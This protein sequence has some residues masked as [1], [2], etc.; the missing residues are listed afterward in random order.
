MVVRFLLGPGV[1]AACSLALGLRGKLLHIAIV[2]SSYSC[3]RVNR[4]RKVDM[5]D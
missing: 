2:Q 3:N 4:A 5:L 1:M